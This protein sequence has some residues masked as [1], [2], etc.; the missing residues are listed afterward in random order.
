[1]AS[2]NVRFGNVERGLSED[3]ARWVAEQLHTRRSGHHTVASDLAERLELQAEAGTFAAPA[4]DVELDESEKDELIEV[5]DAL[6]LNA[7]LTGNVRS[8]HRALR[9]E[10]WPGETGYR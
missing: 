10:R 3:D 9:G 7:Q 1:M 2:V 6:D 5:L 4:L 8:L